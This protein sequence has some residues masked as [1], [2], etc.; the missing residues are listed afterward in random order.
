[1][2]WWA[3]MK[4]IVL[5]PSLMTVLK[6]PS[7]TLLSRAV[8]R[9]HSTAFLPSQCRSAYQLLGSPDSN[10]PFTILMVSLN[11]P[12]TALLSRAKFWLHSM[13]VL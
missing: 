4:I 11:Y 8:F 10:R 5:S 2:S 13:V 3:V 1:M 9:M 7:T 6:P 12:N